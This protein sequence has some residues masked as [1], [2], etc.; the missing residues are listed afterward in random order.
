MPNSRYTKIESGSTWLTFRLS[1]MESPID[2]S[3]KIND[4]TKKRSIIIDN[5]KWIEFKCRLETTDKHS[6]CYIKTD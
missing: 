3:I 4:V 1:I 5:I 6:T 2:D